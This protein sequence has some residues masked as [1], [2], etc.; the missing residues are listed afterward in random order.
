M[1]QG[2]GCWPGLRKRAPALKLEDEQGWPG[3]SW[4]RLWCEVR[5]AG[6][7][8]VVGP[9]RNRLLDAQ[10]ISLCSWLFCHCF[11]FQCSWRSLA[12][13][14]EVGFVLCGFKDHSYF[15]GPIL[16]EADDGFPGNGCP[17][18]LFV[19]TWASGLWKT[20]PMCAIL[21][22][23][24]RHSQHPIVWVWVGQAPRGEKHHRTSVEGAEG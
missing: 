6:L 12:Q 4:G 17:R 15:Q 23:V 14:Q 10:D 1:R 20:A 24:R 11:W 16:Y 13:S 2:S 22:Q 8:G 18:S 9:R 19:S 7:R 21:H 3:S 5:S